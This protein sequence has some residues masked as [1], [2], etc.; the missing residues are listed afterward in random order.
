RDRRERIYQGGICVPCGV[1]RGVHLLSG[2]DCCARFV[3]VQALE[4]AHTPFSSPCSKASPSLRD[5]CSAAV[6]F[7]QADIVTARTLAHLARVCR[8]Q[9]KV[10]VAIQMYERILRIHEALPEPLNSD[11]AVALGEL[12]ALCEEGGSQGSADI[13]RRRADVIMMELGARAQTAESSE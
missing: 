10:D 12:A 4:V 8:L 9:R 1:W 11:H 6:I 5:P 3:R 2:L 13:L 7:L